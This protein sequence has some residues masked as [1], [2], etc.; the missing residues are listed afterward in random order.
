MWRERQGVR[1]GSPTF[2]SCFLV[3]VWTMASS[4]MMFPTISASKEGADIAG[5]SICSLSPN[6]IATFGKNLLEQFCRCQSFTPDQAKAIRAVLS[7]GD[8]P[9]GPPSEWTSSV[10]EELKCL[11]H[12]FDRSLLDQ[13]PRDVLLPWMKDFLRS[14]HLPREQLAA[15]VEKLS[16]RK[17]AAECPPDKTV[18]QKVV[19]DNLMPLDYTPEELQ[20]CLKGPILV[21]NLAVLTDYAFTYEQL[22]VIKENLDEV[23]RDLWGDR[24]R[25]PLLG[26]VRVEEHWLAWFWSLR[27][28]P[29]DSPGW[30]SDAEAW[31]GLRSLAEQQMYP[32]GY[33][34]SIISNLGPLVDFMNLDDIKKWKFTSPDTLA[35]LLGKLT[36]E[37]LAPEIINQYLNSGG[38]LNGEAL[39]AIGSPS[40][41]LLSKDQLN[42]I[43][44]AALKEVKSLDLSKCDQTT[45]NILYSKAKKAFSDQENKFPEYYDEIRPYLGGA[46]VEA[47]RALSSRNVNMDIPTFMGLRNDSVMGLTAEEVKGLLGKNLAG[48]KNEQ[49][50]FPIKDWIRKQKQSDLDKL[51]IGL[52]GGIPVGYINIMPRLD[53]SSETSAAHPTTNVHALPVSATILLTL[54]L[55]SLLS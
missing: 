28:S 38:A 18:T 50:N 10:L 35:S 19:S 24:I 14:S 40:I 48:L 4:Q 42:R 49:D 12:L 15:V 9:F 30:L 55:T 3:V 22:L 25:G 27:I 29:S 20:A 2:L 39:N 16:R 33:P 47:L 45:K 21:D 53:S 11:F 37:K 32:S 51:R 26:S 17:R 52:R 44:E 1:R 41:C 13:I 23:M 31:P 34:D 8:T 6:A 7:S 46:P 36:D 54:L 5:D 43:N